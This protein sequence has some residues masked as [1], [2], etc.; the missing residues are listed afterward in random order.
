MSIHGSIGTAI[1]TGGYASYARR[2]IATYR[3][4]RNSL[5]APAVF[6]LSSGFLTYP[7]DVDEGYPTLRRAIEDDAM[8]ALL[9]PAFEVDACV[10][11]IVRR[12]L[13]RPYLPGNR[14]SEERRIRE[15]WPRFMALP[16]ARFLS[17][18]QPIAIASQIEQFVRGHL[19][20]F[21]ISREFGKAN[22]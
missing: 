6:A 22:T 16:C 12:Q 14:D 10:E 13:A 21:E 3:A 9:L 7:D 4:V 2:N 1:A 5:E 8:T 17:D 15:R 11:I 19:E 18:A 20:R